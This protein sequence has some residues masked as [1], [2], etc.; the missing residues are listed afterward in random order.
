MGNYRRRVDIIA[1]ILG[2]VSSDAKKTQIMFKANL[3]YKVLTKY[4]TEILDASLITFEEERQCYMLTS[5][6]HDFLA[7]YKIYYK[8]NK[9]LEKR[10]SHIMRTKRTLDELCRPVNN[11]DN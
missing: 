6:G 3:S 4:L 9:Y 2:V 10:L 5:K 11:E 7:N 1:D 8:T